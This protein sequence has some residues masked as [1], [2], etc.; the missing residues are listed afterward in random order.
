MSWLPGD[1][2]YRTGLKPKSGN[3]THVTCQH[4]PT[5]D[6]AYRNASF[7]RKGD[8]IKAQNANSDTM[9]SDLMHGNC[10]YRGAGFQSM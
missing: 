8:A 1:K 4:P 9:R 5:H 3:V 10:Y 7:T 6:H 2:S